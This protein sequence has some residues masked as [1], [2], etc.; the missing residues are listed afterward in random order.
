MSLLLTEVL[1]VLPTVVLSVEV[2]GGSN[3]TDTSLGS[4]LKSEVVL[5]SRNES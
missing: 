2:V 5:A 4:G 3:N 1:E